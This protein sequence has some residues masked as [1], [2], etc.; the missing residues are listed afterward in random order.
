[1]N[2]Q[3]GKGHAVLQGTWGLPSAPST[4]PHPRRCP[5][6]GKSA[7]FGPGFWRVGR[8]QWNIWEILTG[9][10]KY[11]LDLE[12][13]L[14][15]NVHNHHNWCSLSHPPVPSCRCCLEVVP[16]RARSSAWS[17]E[18]WSHRGRT[19]RWART[20]RCPGRKHFFSRARG[21]IPVTSSFHS[22]VRISK[23]PCRQ[24]VPV[25]PASAKTVEPLEGRHPHQS[26]SCY[27]SSGCQHH[28]WQHQLSKGC[29]N[30]ILGSK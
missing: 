4:W 11:S 25:I 19:S 8:V 10:G 28:L 23:C 21:E 16:S 30:R 9:Y 5:E 12:I 24:N 1:M 2:H 27:R 20:A 26:T 17:P 7:G 14:V 3:V 13:F 18:E 6:P 29:I 15:A 22:V